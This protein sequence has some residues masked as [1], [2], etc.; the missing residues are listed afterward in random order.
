MMSRVQRRAG[1]FL[2]AI[3]LVLLA[4]CGQAHESNPSAQGTAP[5]PSQKTPPGSQPSP[6]VSGGSFLDE[7][8]VTRAA[9]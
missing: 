7:S 8:T 5:K 1:I 6:A 3:A 2:A 4:A 9:W